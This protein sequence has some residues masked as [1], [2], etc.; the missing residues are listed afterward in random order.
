MDKI[1]FGVIGSGFIGQTHAEA[2]AA[3]DGAVLVAVAGGRRAA[4]LAAKHR[5]DCEPT[6]EALIARSDIDAVVIATP[7]HLHADEAVQA[8]ESGKHAL[9]EKPITTTLEDCDRVLEAATRRGKTLAVGHQQR[10]RVNNARACELIRSNAIGE[11]RTVQVSM[12]IYMGVLEE[13]GF[14]G[15][16]EWW[17]LPESVGHIINSG[18]HAVDLLRWFTGA[19]VVSVSAFSRTFRPGQVVEDTSLVHF[20]FSNGM[21]CSL[22]SSNALPGPSFPGEDFRFRILGSTGLMDLDPYHELRMTGADGWKVMSTQ[23]PFT[24]GDAENAFGDVRMQAYKDQITAFLD[25]VHG[26]EMRCANGMDGRA[27]LE[28]CLAALQSSRERRWVQTI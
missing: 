11:L 19:N 14:G 25:A 20:E 17:T 1:R 10:F 4:A 15:K 5:I 7:H 13:G 16:W 21:L 2:I 28:A 24:Y 27:G 23:P 26:K 12:P 18:P 8:I 9:V 6:V 22:Y 3:V